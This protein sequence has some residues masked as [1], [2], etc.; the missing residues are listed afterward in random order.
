[1]TD[2][3]IIIVD[4]GNEPTQ[5]HELRR[6]IQAANIEVV[7]MTRDEISAAMTKV[8]ISE[9]QLRDL[10]P[11]LSAPAP[12]PTGANRRSRRAARRH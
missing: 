9:P 3:K 2:T 5:L 6:A 11:M 10:T 1:M 12:V 4:A 7:V 8:V